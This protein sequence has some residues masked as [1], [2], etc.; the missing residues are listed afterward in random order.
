VLAGRGAIGLAERLEDHA[1]L[2]VGDPDP[3]VADHE[4]MA[5]VV[6]R[7]L[8]H[9][10]P[11]L[12]ELERVRQQVLQD[13]FQ[14]LRI[15]LDHERVAAAHS[16]RE[17]ALAGD[18]GERAHEIVADADERDLVD[19]DVEHPGLDLGEIEDVVDHRQQIVA[20]GVDRLG[21]PD[22]LDREVAV[23]VLGQEL[24]QDQRAVERR[25]QLVRHVGEELRLGAVGALGALRLDPDRVLGARELLVVLLEQAS[26]TLQHLVGLFELDLL[27]LELLLAVGHRLTALLELLVRRAQL[28]VLLLERGRL[29]PGFIEQLLE[30]LAIHRGAH[31]DRDRLGDAIEQ[32][33]GDTIEVP[34]HA[35]LEHGVGPVAVVRRHH[36]ELPR[37]G[38]AEARSHH[39]VV[40]RHVDEPR[41]ARGRGLADDALTAREGLG[42]IVGIEREPRPAVSVAIRVDGVERGDRG[43]DHRGEVF[44]DRRPELGERLPDLEPPGQRR[45]ALEHELDLLAL[46]DEP[47]ADH[48]RDDELQQRRE[49]VV[50]DRE[51]PDRRDV[52]VVQH[53]A[54]ED[55]RQ[56][57]RTWPADLRGEHHRGDEERRREQPVRDRPVGEQ[58]GQ[59]CRDRDPPSHQR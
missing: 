31:R 8:E 3:G 49:E 4:A 9:H 51:R 56:D 7:D 26:L 18:R 35:K 11:A 16:E 45:V 47:R 58:R 13:L 5:G 15:G 34:E 43:A 32:M 38:P 52:V 41:P 46:L 12:G 39:D 53:P 42:R 40:R 57:R 54:G 25:P 33:L 23:A 10:L 50:A 59:R 29:A 14:P 48:H 20:R 22:L 55:K 37:P 27:L 6:G 1:E 17:A 19:L 44:E 28:F 2:V 36:H 24:G 21:K 30:L